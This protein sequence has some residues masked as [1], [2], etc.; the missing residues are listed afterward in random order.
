MS[1]KYLGATSS[2]TGGATSL[3]LAT[4]AI[5]DLQPGDLIFLFLAVQAYVATTIT[6][7]AT[8]VAELSPAAAGALLVATALHYVG[9]VAEPATYAFGY[10]SSKPMIGVAAA[11]RGVKQ[12]LLFDPTNYPFGYY[13]PAGSA[14]AALSQ[15]SAAAIVSPVAGS[16]LSPYGRVVLFF[17]G[18]HASATPHLSDVAPLA[19]IRAKVQEAKLSAALCDVL[20]PK[21]LAALPSYSVASS[22]TL[23]SAFGVSRTFE[24]IVAANDS[25]DSYKAKVMRGMI[26]PPYRGRYADLIPKIV[27]VIG[28][29]DNDIDGLFGATDFLPDEV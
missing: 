24:P 25:F 8:W 15:P 11:Y 28:G 19:A 10:G 12:D 7:P 23:A 2:A 5:D 18:T 16:S 6:V 14:R 21:V 29:G 3:T 26:P 17:A 20:E 1:V 27:T 13:A 22:V 4:P 9:D